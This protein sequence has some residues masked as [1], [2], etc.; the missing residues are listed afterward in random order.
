MTPHI[1][2]K[3]PRYCNA[4]AEILRRHDNGEPEVNITSAVRDLLIGTGLAR[5]EE[6]V[7]ENPPSAG[8]RLAVDLPSLD[9]ARRRS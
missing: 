4:A 7:E 9:A 2:P 6:M 5:G 3:D 8:P 1:D